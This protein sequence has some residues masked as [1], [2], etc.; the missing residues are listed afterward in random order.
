MF[1]ADRAK[2]HAL[3]EAQVA[4]AREDEAV[5]DLMNL[6]E[7]FGNSGARRASSIAPRVPAPTASP[8]RLLAIAASAAVL[9][10]AAAVA[11]VMHTPARMQTPAPHANAELLVHVVPA[12]ATITLDG[13]ALSGS[14]PHG[15]FPLD[16]AQHR[17]FA[18]APGYVP[19]S[20]MVILDSDKVTLD[21]TLEPAVAAAPTP[22]ASGTASVSEP[23]GATSH[24][25]AVAMGTRRAGAPT[26]TST[27]PSVAVEAA[28]PAAAAP[29]PSASTAH[30]PATRPWPTSPALDKT[31][32]WASPPKP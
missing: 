28:A 24:K 10:G 2:I 20:D 26:I 14:P 22:P 21:M 8:R 5:D 7:Y 1:E 4:K 3:I 23:A 9:G 30:A 12:N 29:V 32:P 19:Y 25:P 13:V 15:V 6:S 17:V 18:E 31:D 16:G 27:T 11:Y